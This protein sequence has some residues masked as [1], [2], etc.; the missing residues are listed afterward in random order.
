MNNRSGAKRPYV[1]R[2][3]ACGSEALYAVQVL[4][5]TIGRG[6]SKANRKIKLGEATILCGKCG[7][8]ADAF[9]EKLSH[10]SIAAL[11]KVRR[12][13]RSKPAPDAPLFDQAEA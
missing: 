4:V 3:C 2:A 9:I 5:R 10:S 8:N 1:P 7:R 13:R 12:M 11:D 6:Q